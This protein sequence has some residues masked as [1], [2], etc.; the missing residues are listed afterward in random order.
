MK[1][2]QSEINRTLKTNFDFPHSPVYVQVATSVNNIPTIRTLRLYDVSK[3]GEM[4]FLSHT[5]TR[6]WTD[7]SKNPYMTVHALDKDNNQLISSG[8][9]TLHIPAEDKNYINYWENLT[10]D[11]KKLY[12]GPPPNQKLETAPPFFVPEKVPATFGVII[13]KPNFYEWYEVDWQDLTKSTR[14]QFLFGQ[15][16]WVKKKVHPA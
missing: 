11:D 2:M 1:F 6:K 8:R 7:L 14:T 16:R 10:Q 3:E 5:Q 12:A 9:A 4:I 15:H 13:M